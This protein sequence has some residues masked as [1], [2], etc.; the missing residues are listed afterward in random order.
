MDASVVVTFHVILG[1]VCQYRRQLRRASG[2]T[3]SSIIKQSK[4]RKGEMPPHVCRPVGAPAAV[5]PSDLGELGGARIGAES[6]PGL[7][8]RGCS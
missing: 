6:G 8:V 2:W 3:I 7:K 4:R 1:S 5:G